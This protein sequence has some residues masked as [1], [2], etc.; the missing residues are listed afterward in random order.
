MSEEKTI[1]SHTYKSS[2]ESLMKKLPPK[3]IMLAAAVLAFIF[4][5]LFSHASMEE[6]TDKYINIFSAFTLFVV[7]IIGWVFYNIFSLAAYRM[8]KNRIRARGT[9]VNGK[10]L[11]SAMVRRHGSY[12]YIFTVKTDDGKLFESE[13]YTDDH[14]KNDNCT[15][16]TVYAYKDE[17]LIGEFIEI[18]TEEKEDKEDG[19]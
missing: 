17:Y 2:A 13:G 14:C 10:I 11:R 8:H 16:C 19:K 9:Q 15:E 7:F 6:L 1:K 3:L 18:V 12:R 5:C 4:F